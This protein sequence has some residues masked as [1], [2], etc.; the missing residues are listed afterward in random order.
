MSYFRQKI[1]MA[2]FKFI[3]EAGV[4]IPEIKQKGSHTASKS[5][6][7]EDLEDNHLNHAASERLEQQVHK[8]GL[9][10]RSLNIQVEGQTVHLS[11]TVTNQELKEKL[12]LLVGN[13]QGISEVEEQVRV[14]HKGDEAHFHTVTVEDNLKLIAQKY[15]AN[16]DRFPE[17]IEA[18]KPFISDENDLYPGMVIRIIGVGKQ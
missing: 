4:Q 3:L 13:V 1:D 7:V 11:A 10:V 15:L 2:Q 18:N 6:K 14:D 5:R 12:I 16:K 9:S 8:L 17:I